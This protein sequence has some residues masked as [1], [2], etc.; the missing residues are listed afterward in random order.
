MI[1]RHREEKQRRLQENKK[2]QEHGTLDFV[3]CLSV[4]LSLICL[5]CLV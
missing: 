4:S 5:L 1:Q 3:F 2:V